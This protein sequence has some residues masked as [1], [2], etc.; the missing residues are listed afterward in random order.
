MNEMKHKAIF[1]ARAFTLIVPTLVTS[2][3]RAQE[4][5]DLKLTIV[6]DAARAPDRQPINRM[7][8]DMDKSMAKSA[9]MESL[10]FG[11][12]GTSNGRS[13]RE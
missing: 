1:F 5:A 2:T 12:K 13:C 8:R 6:Y 7:M 4:W 10:R 9:S 11:R 3:L